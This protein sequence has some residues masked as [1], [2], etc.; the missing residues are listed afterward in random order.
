MQIWSEIMSGG[1]F[2]FI[3]ALFLRPAFRPSITLLSSIFNIL[4]SRPSKT[5][6]S[7]LFETPLLP[8]PLPRLGTPTVASEFQL[9]VHYQLYHGASGSYWEV[10]WV[11]STNRV[12]S[13]RVV[14]L[15]EIGRQNH[16][17]QSVYHM[18]DL[19]IPTHSAM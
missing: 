11:R 1:I 9:S 13:S 4:P 19:S 18:R 8:P 17:L 7:R 6:P 15:G 16:G 12:T 14:A 3:F 5:L 2:F 10:C